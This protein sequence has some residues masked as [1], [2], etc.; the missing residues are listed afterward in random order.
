MEIQSQETKELMKALM[1]ARK[2][3][4]PI[5]KDTE[6]YKYKYANFNS[7]LE[8]CEEALDKNGLI[9]VQQI[10]MHEKEC[11]MVTTLHHESGQWIRTF[12]PIINSKGDC[13]GFG[14]SQTYMRRYSME[15]ILGCVAEKDDDGAKA[16]EPPK[17]SIDPSEPTQEQIN[18]FCLDNKIYTNDP[19]SENQKLMKYI[20]FLSQSEV[21]KQKLPNIKDRMDHIL[22]SAVIR[23]KV[24]FEQFEKWS[25]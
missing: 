16:C 3:F 11:L 10:V 15:C 23:Q 6:A 24:F 8:A 5:L 12:S 13:Q 2:E 18:K 25:K 22:K 9:L 7:Y 14:S 4:K 21:M 1:Q 19:S 20:S 17:K